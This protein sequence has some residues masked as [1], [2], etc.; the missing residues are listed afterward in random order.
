MKLNHT[1]T[2]TAGGLPVVLAHGLFGQGRNMGAIA[3]RLAETRRVVTP[4]MRN[5]GES[6]HADV[7]DYPAMAADLAGLIEDLGGRADLVGHSMGGKAAMMLALRRPELLRKLVVMDIAPIAYRHSQNGL[8]DAMEAV[9]MAGITRRSE[10][11][12][13]LAESIHSAGLRAF[14]LQSL[15][16]KS[17]PPRWRLNLPVLRQQMEVI[18]GWPEG[19]CGDGPSAFAGPALAMLGAQSDYVDA[20]GQ[21][22]LRRLFPQIRIVTLKEAGHW[23]HA[24]APE[25]VAS[26]L[27]AFLGEG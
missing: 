7:H 2:G 14:L 21:H 3:R 19:D 9:D 1:I 11:D 27:A 25:A 20:E 16:L 4:D 8:I 5:H 13:A 17:R 26:T 22:A 15:D 12:A 23:L 6:P 24:D 10:A 18:T